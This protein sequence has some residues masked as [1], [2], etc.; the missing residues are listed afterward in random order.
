MKPTSNVRNGHNGRDR[1]PGDHRRIVST[2]ANGNGAMPVPAGPLGQMTNGHGRNGNCKFGAK[3]ALAHLLPDGRRVNRPNFSHMNGGHLNLGGRVIPDHYAHQSALANSLHQANV[4]PPSAAYGHQYHYSSKEDF[5]TLQQHQQQRGNSHIDNVPN[6]ETGLSSNPGSPYGSPREEDYGHLSSN[7]LTAR[8][9]PMPASFESNGISWNA[10]YGPVAASVP[11]KFGMGSPPAFM[12]KDAK[13]SGA[14][15]N[16]QESAYGRN[17]ISAMSAIGTSMGSMGSSPPA[18]EFGIRRTMHSQRLPKHSITSASLPKQPVNDDWDDGFAFEEELLPGSLQDLLTPQ[19]KMRRYSRTEED[20]AAQRPSFSGF[21]T[22]GESSS[23][24]GSPTVGSPSRFGALFSRQKKDEEG[25]MATSAFGHVGSPLRNSSLHPDASP[26]MHAVSRPT[27]GEVSPYFASP[28]RQSS[29]SMISQQLQRTRLSKSESYSNEQN[30]GLH[31][32]SAVTRPSFNSSSRLDRAVSS[33][34]IGPP[35]IEEEKE[36]F[37]FPMEEE[38]DSKSKSSS[39]WTNGV[40]TRSPR[41]S[42]LGVRSSNPA[43]EGTPF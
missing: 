33:T 12:T 20:T 30:A 42:S 22:P 14:V 10:R 32:S 4:G 35:R 6:I 29:M 9:A 31:P 36:D 38:E 40:N 2:G 11:T 39:F 37:V 34:S 16:L 13:P 3:C 26:S 24:V 1:V 21:G 23:K 7:H 8:D 41:H 5:P 43:T 17:K 15:K 28:P 18:S 27:S 19:E 25:G